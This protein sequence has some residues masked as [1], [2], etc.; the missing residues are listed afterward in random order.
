MERKSSFGKILWEVGGPLLLNEVLTVALQS[1][2]GVCFSGMLSQQGAQVWMLALVNTVEIPVFYYLYCR[3]RKKDGLEADGRESLWKT[4]KSVK[5]ERL[6]WAI[7][8]GLFLG[9]GFNALLGLTPLPR[10]FPGYAPAV[11]GLYG[12]SVL[13]VVAASV[14]AAPI[15]EELLFR[16]IIYGSLKRGLPSS[17]AALICASLLF[18]I[19]H[20][21][22][23]QGVFAF[24]VGLFLNWIY[25]A[26]GS[27]LPAILAHSAVNAST[28]FLAVAEPEWLTA[29]M[30]Q[31]PFY[32]VM[33]AFCLLAGFWCWKKFQF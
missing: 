12:G 8:G 27:L 32:L 6:L 20:G 19:L 16:G 31:T 3:S 2:F 15:L 30:E 24:L 1:V 25:E 18:G 21:N 7:L 29:L 23:V 22:V 9:R 14:L 28:V 11:E 5:P 26:E 17:R 33:T 13:A 4:G 10:L